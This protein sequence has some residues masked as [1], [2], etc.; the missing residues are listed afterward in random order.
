[1]TRHSYVEEYA[2]PA[3]QRN[4]R[5]FVRNFFGWSLAVGVAAAAIWAPVFSI[6]NW[7]RGIYAGFHYNDAKRFAGYALVGEYGA[8]L[9]R[10]LVLAKPDVVNTHIAGPW[11]GEQVRIFHFVGPRGVKYCVSVW[12]DGRD[13]DRWQVQKW[14]KF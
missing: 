10:Q 8:A 3:K 12:H 2:T 13:T 7:Q 14:C 9:T 5:K 4:Y 1:M 6:I 11:G